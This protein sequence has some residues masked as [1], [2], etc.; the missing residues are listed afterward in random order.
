[1]SE[2]VISIKVRDRIAVTESAEPYICGN[3]DY[4]VQFDF[5]EE[6]DAYEAKTARFTHGGIF[7]DVVFEGNSCP[8]P[9]IMNAY[10]F[11]VGVYAGDLWVTTAARV[12][13]KKSVL[14]ENA[15]PQKPPESVYNKIMEML[16]KALRTVNGIAPDENG[17]V[18]VASPKERY[19]LIETI[20]TE[21]EIAIVRTEEPNGTPYNF[22]AVALR[23]KKKEG[24]RLNTVSMTAHI[25]TNRVQPLYLT[26]TNKTE[27]LWSYCEVRQYKGLWERERAQGWSIKNNTETP[28]YV[29]LPEFDNPVVDGEN[30]T[31][32]SSAS[33]P[34]GLTIEIWGVRA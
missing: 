2:R 30:I 16:N 8:V 6:W 23:V 5:D 18:I 21:E 17:N 1:M 10:E 19:E 15:A 22:V 31:K 11:Y 13:S 28:F 7:Q 20:T 34:A 26:S 4:V 29:K 33:V 24:M 25:G 12:L 9:A 14:C 3:T 27:E 32:I